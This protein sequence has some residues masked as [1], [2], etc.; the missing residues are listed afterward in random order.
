[1]GMFATKLHTCKVF[2]KIN[3]KLCLVF[4][5][6]QDNQVIKMI[7]ISIVTN[8]SI[9]LLGGYNLS[10]CVW[11]A[12]SNV[13]KIERHTINILQVIVVKTTHDK[14]IISRIFHFVTF[15]SNPLPVFKSHN[16]HVTWNFLMGVFVA[17]KFHLSFKT[18][19]NTENFYEK[20]GV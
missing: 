20:H 17:I 8:L 12:I 16:Y 10:E 15:L 3:V 1:M 18:S 11:K 13:L 4:S 19:P 9:V 14:I 5:L 7:H 2:V 6:I